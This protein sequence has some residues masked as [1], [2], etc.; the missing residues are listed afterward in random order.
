MHVHICICSHLTCL[1]VREL[2]SW[3]W[4]CCAKAV[5]DGSNYLSCNVCG[6]HLKTTKSFSTST[7]INHLKSKHG[8]SND[9]EG[10]IQTKLSTDSLFPK[11]T[12]EGLTLKA[13]EMVVKD[14][15]PVSLVEK[16]GMSSIMKHLRP[17]LKVPSA[18]HVRKL[19]C[20]LEEIGCDV[21]KE[22]LSTLENCHITTDGWS[23]ARARGFGSL[24]VSHVSKDW[25]M[26][27]LPASIERIEGRHTSENLAKWLGKRLKELKLRP[28]T[29]TTDNAS[30]Q[31]KCCKAMVDEGLV[32]AFLGCTPHVLHLIVKRVTCSKGVTM[33]DLLEDMEED[34]AEECEED[35]EDD[36]DADH[37][38]VQE[39]RVQL[40]DEEEE[41]EHDDEQ[42]DDPKDAD[43]FPVKKML[44]KLR[45]LVAM[46]RKSNNMS[47]LLEQT[48]KEDEDWDRN[49]RVSIDVT[50]R[51]SSTHLMCKRATLLKEHI[52]PLKLKAKKTLKLGKK[53]MSKFLNDDDWDLCAEL[54]KI[55]GPFFAATRQL[56]GQKCVTASKV[57]A[58]WRRIQL[59]LQKQMDR[60]VHLNSDKIV[61]VLL[62]AMDDLW[63]EHLEHDIWKVASAVDPHHKG[64]KFV[65]KPEREDIWRLV[66]EEMKAVVE[67]EKKAKAL[68][69][70]DENEEEKA[71]VKVEAE[72]QEK[73]D[74]ELLDLGLSS[75]DNDDQILD[76]K[77]DEDDTSLKLELHK[78]RG[79]KLKTNPAECTPLQF[80]QVNAPE[81]P[82]LS[83]VA[84]CHLGVNASAVASERVFSLTGHTMSK[85]R[86]KTSGKLLCAILFLNQCAK[87]K[88]LWDTIVARH[89]E[90]QAE[91][92]QEPQK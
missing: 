23:D 40:H 82:T 51:W 16:D 14:L 70:Q 55:L 15:V 68:K 64:L 52:E 73:D 81:F 1:N 31:K 18:H 57:L 54:T 69:E 28:L 43:M 38:D 13:L 60:N 80:W 75:S 77:V 11:P 78:C 56:S 12:Q 24:T 29:I 61:Q 20:A 84:S 27:S 45:G 46:M 6:R 30:N 32:K 76:V 22:E 25:E 5:K 53:Q 74:D 41:G 90:M 8:L 48:Q 2:S 17:Q 50:T 21:V 87:R 86:N 19:M 71:L 33:K 83:K 37:N 89:K 59:A 36:V 66:L 65:K 26:K 9:D 67:A 58:L 63:N 72:E 85:R 39:E 35:G 42:E 44:K 3:A 49:L 62:D 34:E 7:I 79:M 88:W 47:E 4:K 92:E 10:M 91:K